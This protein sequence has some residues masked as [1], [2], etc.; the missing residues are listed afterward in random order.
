MSHPQP[1]PQLPAPTVAPV[2]PPDTQAIKQDIIAN[3]E[4]RRKRA[5]GQAANML[6]PTGTGQNAPTA[7]AQLLGQ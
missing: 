6:A 1:A 4:K 5:Q 3:D 7:A 2:A